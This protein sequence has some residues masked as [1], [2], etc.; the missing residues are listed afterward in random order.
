M[1]LSIIIVSFNTRDLLID[2]LNSLQVHYKREFTEKQFEIIVVDNASK[3]GTA[4]EIKNKFPKIC[5][6]ENKKNVG[7]AKANNQGVTKAQGKII[8]F[9][10]PDTV[11]PQNTLLVTHDYMDK[12]PVVGI[13]TCKVLLANGEI[14]DA[15]HRGAITYFTGL[16]KLFPQSQLFNGYHL[17]YKLMDTIHE[18]DSCVGAF[19]MIKREIGDKL[20]WFDEDYFWYGDDLD[21]CFRAKQAG[22]KVMYVPTVSIIHY[23]GAAS[24]IKKHS[25]H[26]SRADS[27]TKKL[28]TAARY[29]VM[30]IFYRKHY[31]HLYP[32]WM[33]SLVFLGIALKQ[34]L[35]EVTV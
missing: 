32:K 22:Y 16:G 27:E 6:F 1:K 18:I 3:D 14:D 35:S 4:V 12:N 29:E 13:S 8:L 17:G 26:L 2:C 21:L 9:L 28:V 15:S 31:Q 10:N 19:L 34:K 33:T 30:R 11:I 7:F 23:K 24:G 5:L 20:H 25:Q